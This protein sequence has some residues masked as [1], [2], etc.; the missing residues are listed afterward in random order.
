MTGTEPASS[1]GELD[2]PI[3]KLMQDKNPRSRF[4]DSKKNTNYTRPF[5]PN[6]QRQNATVMLQMR[7]SMA[8]TQ[9]NSKLKKQSMQLQVADV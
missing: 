1:V 7:E 2:D 8:N 9:R 4:K 5:K 6:H 3:S